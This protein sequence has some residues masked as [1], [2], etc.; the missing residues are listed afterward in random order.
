[1]FPPGDVVDLGAGHGKF[2]R[3]AADAGWRVTAVDARSDRWP[4]DDRIEWRQADVRDVDLA[5]YDLVLCLGLF[6]HLTVDDQLDLLR[7]VQVPVIIDTHLDHGVHQHELSEP[8]EQSGYQGRLY[9]EGGP[10]NLLASWGNAASFWPTLPSFQRMLRDCGFPVLLTAEPPVTADR[11]V[12]VA[13]PEVHRRPEVSSGQ[14]PRHRGSP[15]LRAAAA[16]FKA[17]T[18]SRSPRRSR[19]SASR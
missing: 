19:G 5:G 18:S 8:V 10:H 9:K 16:R 2:S 6:Y 1:M 17:A 7:R 14:Q 4:G 11:W 15:R 3:L 12:F 13:L